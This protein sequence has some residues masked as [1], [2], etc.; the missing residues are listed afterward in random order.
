MMLNKCIIQWF[1]VDVT[2]KAQKSVIIRKAGAF[3][4]VS[5]GTYLSLC[6][7]LDFKILF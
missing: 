5:V 6:Q 2:T 4:S 3:N 1:W 7:G